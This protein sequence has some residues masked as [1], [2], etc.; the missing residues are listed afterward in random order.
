MIKEFVIRKYDSSH[1]SE[2]DQKYQY[3]LIAVTIFN[4]EIILSH[5]FSSV[6]VSEEEV[7]RTLLGVVDAHARYE[8]QKLH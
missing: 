4:D 6:E 7:R 3:N 5:L 1:Q 2:S 8:E